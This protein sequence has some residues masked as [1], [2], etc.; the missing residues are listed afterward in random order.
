[1]KKLLILILAMGVA[2]TLSA[3]VLFG[4]KAGY[5]MASLNYSGSAINDLGVKSDF[6]AGLFTSIPLFSMFYLQPEIVYSGQGSGFT[7]SIPANANY[8][9]LNI[10]VLFKFQHPSGFFAE[11]GPQMGFLLSANIKSNGHTIDVKA[12]T[13]STDFSWV[14]GIGYKIPAIHV[15]IDLRY[16]L[17]L[18]NTIE[19]DNNNSGVAKNSVFQIDLFYQFKML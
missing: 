8:D 3:Q 16:N 10:P 14:L 17:G 19:A 4:V 13:Q 9:Y 6:N 11:T 7:D 1:M 2:S 15:G 5:N 18:T 12:N